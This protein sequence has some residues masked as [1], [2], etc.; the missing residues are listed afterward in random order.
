MSVVIIGHVKS[1]GLCEPLAGTVVKALG[2]RNRVM[3]QCLSDENGVWSLSLTEGAQE[4]RFEKEGYAPKQIPY[5]DAFPKLIRLLENETIGYQDKLWFL[6]GETVHARIHSPQPF[7]ARLFRFGLAVKEILNL[8]E[9]PATAQDVSDHVFV[10]EGLN[11]TKTVAYAIP[12]DAVP[13][14]YGLRLIPK[15]GETYYITFLVSTPFDQSREPSDLLVLASTNNWETYNWWGGRSR[16][17]NYEA[18]ARKSFKGMLHNVGMKYMPEALKPRV[19]Q[20]LGKHLV[21]SIADHPDDWQFQPL[22][23]RRPHPDLSIPTD[24]VSS[25][26]QS[27]LAPG[28]W[29]VLAWLEKHDIDYDIVSGYELHTRPELMQRYK[30]IVLSTHSEY[31]SRE[32]FGGL[33]AFHAQGG[34][35]LNLS[36]NSIYREIEY[37]HQ[38]DIRCRSLR[39]AHSVEDESSLIGVRFDYRGYMTAAP[40]EV[41]KQDHWVFQDT[42]VARGDLFAGTSLN[43][44]PFHDGGSGWE[45]DKITDTAPEDV[46]LLAKGRNPKNG[47][48]DMIIREPRNGSGWMFSASSITFGGSLLI[49]DVSSKIVLNVLSRTGVDI[50]GT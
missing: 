1:A 12:D 9:Y 5:R 42:H 41:V 17:K 10:Q 15:A 25:Q 23:I 27:H 19:R 35:I 32:M 3:D 24:D 49:D 2:S 18:E 31:W 36:G 14:L 34:S 40:Y 16:Y 45:T 8:G 13:G 38:H 44:V 7:E 48:S 6:P 28:E 46:I 43:N 39:F 20:L 29:R 47:G 33:K 22:S 30:A 4:V 26:F 21:V 50:G 37:V 11:W